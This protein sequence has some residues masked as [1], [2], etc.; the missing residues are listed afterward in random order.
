MEN[1]LFLNGQSIKLHGVE[2]HETNPVLGRSLKVGMWTADV[3]LLHEANMNYVF[4]SHYPVPEE[5]L[6]ACDQVGVLVTEEMP[7]VW[8]GWRT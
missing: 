8:V 5:F 1:Q 6:D 4:T 3:K 2:R 7:S